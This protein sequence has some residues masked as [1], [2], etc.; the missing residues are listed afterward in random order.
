[1]RLAILLLLAACGSPPDPAITTDQPTVDAGPSPCV[2]QC[3][4]DWHTCFSKGVALNFSVECQSRTTTYQCC[5]DATYRCFDA[6]G[7]NAAETG[8]ESGC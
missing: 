4:V 5:A 6:T 2:Q 8:C 3:Q 1:M 7:C